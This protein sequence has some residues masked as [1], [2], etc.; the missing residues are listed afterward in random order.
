MMSDVGGEVQAALEAVASSLDVAGSIEHEHRVP[1]HEAREPP[2]L[3]KNVVNSM[4]QM[5]IDN[6][7]YIRKHPEVKDVLNYF[8]RQ[9]LLNKPEDL[10]DFAADFFSDP[11]LAAKVQGHASVAKNYVTTYGI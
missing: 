5:R 7:Q 4:I 6:E 11:D 2:P 8:M 3:V 9:V 1:I 10:Q